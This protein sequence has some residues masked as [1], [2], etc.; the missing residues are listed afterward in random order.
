MNLKDTSKKVVMT[1]TNQMLKHNA[2][3]TTCVY[4]YQPKMPKQL[5]QFSKIKNDK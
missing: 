5:S 1:M 4:V 3:S 2:N